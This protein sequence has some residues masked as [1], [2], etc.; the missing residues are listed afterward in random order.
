M[1]LAYSKQINSLFWK[2]DAKLKVYS[3]WFLVSENMQMHFQNPTY[4]I[5]QNSDFEK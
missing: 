2:P 5:Y 4:I 1:V 3:S